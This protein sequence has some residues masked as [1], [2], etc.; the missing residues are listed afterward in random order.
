[1]SWIVSGKP[2]TGLPQIYGKVRQVQV[3]RLSYMVYYRLEPKRIVVIAVHHGK[4][5]PQR[6]QSRA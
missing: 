1:M 3:K 6:W 5:D 2:P 4:R